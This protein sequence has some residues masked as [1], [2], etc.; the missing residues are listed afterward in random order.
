MQGRFYKPPLS[1]HEMN[2]IKNIFIILFLLYS[3]TSSL[4]D[5]QRYSVPL[6][7]S[8]SCGARNAKVTF[9][10]FLDYQ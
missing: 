6:E 7:D 9:I 4:A 3:A 5:E 10:E 8:P 2:T 1:N